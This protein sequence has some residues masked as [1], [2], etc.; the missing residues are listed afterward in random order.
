LPHDLAGFELHRGARR[1]DEAAA[2]LIGIATDTRFGQARLEN[3]E[4]AQFDRDI[5][6]QAVGDLIQ[7]SLD[8]IENLVLHHPGLVTDGHDDVAFSELAHV[9]KEIVY[10]LSPDRM[11]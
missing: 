2:W 4:I 10:R 3:A 9:F 5:A 6:S 1:D 8:D 11:V 7:C